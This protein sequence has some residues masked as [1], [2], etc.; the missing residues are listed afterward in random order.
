MQHMLRVS[1]ELKTSSLCS[2][3]SIQYWYK[4][5]GQI[6]GHSSKT[7]SPKVIN[8][9]PWETVSMFLRELFQLNLYNHKKCTITSD[10][11]GQKNIKINQPHTGL[12]V[13]SYLLPT[14]KSRDTQTGTKFKIPAR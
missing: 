6:P 1:Y 4:I 7:C 5:D 10:V 13:D 9:Q 14:S 12:T 8:L 3:I 2:A 11:H